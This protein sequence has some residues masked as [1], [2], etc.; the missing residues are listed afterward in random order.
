MV[1]SFLLRTL[2]CCSAPHPPALKGSHQ[3]HG[4]SVPTSGSLEASVH[5]SFL[6]EMMG[7]WKSIPA[8]LLFLCERQRKAFP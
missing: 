3:R 5:L 7:T 4:G 2:A 6:G 8:Q 1:M